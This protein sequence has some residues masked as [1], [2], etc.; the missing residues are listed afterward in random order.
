MGKIIGIDLLAPHQLGYGRDGGGQPTIIANA[1]AADYRRPSVLRVQ[2]SERCCRASHKRQ[3]V[4]NPDNTIF[5]VKRLIGRKFET[6]RSSS[7]K[8]ALQDRQGNGGVKVTMGEERGYTPEISTV[9][10]SRAQDRR[11]GLPAGHAPVTEAVITVPRPT[12]TTP[13]RQAA[14]RRQITPTSR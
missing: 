5:E 9:I 11:G 10:L 7:T 8:H 4:I 2:N 6:K 12:S 13:Q 3:A 14:R 1:G